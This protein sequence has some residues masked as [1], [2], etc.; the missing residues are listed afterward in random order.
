MN[1]TAKA[2]E[3]WEKPAGDG[4]EVSESLVYCGTCD[5]WYLS[6]EVDYKDIK[7]NVYE[8]D[9]MVF[10]CEVCGKRSESVVVVKR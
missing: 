8:E 4:G 9:V 3:E 2:G 1:E 5:R 7:S 10:R 6:D